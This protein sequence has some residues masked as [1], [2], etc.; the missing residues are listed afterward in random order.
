MGQGLSNK[1][2]KFIV[3]VNTYILVLLL[4]V[5]WELSAQQ[6][7]RPF[8][9]INNSEKPAILEKIEKQAWAGKIYKDFLDRIDQD[10][11]FHQTDRERFLQTLPFDWD[12]REPS[13]FPPFHLTSHMENGI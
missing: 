8:I 11:R 6:A 9:W 12:N 1:L 2:M 10:I 3:K 4:C 5:S 7:E 13:Q